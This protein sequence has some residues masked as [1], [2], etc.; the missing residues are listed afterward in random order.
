M[1]DLP[2]NI[3]DMVVIGVLLLSALLALA[4]GF[5]REVL[6]IAGWVAA[7]FITYFALPHVQKPA[8]QWVAKKFDIKEAMVADVGAGAAIFIA[9]LVVFTIITI[10]ISKRIQE[11]EIGP[12]DRSLGF[13]F[14]LVRGAFVLS[15]AYLVLIQFIPPK[16]HPKWI[17]D[18][19]SL[20]ALQSGALFLTKIS[21]E[22]V[23][24]NLKTTESWSDKLIKKLDDTGS[25][26]NDTTKKLKENY[27]DEQRKQLD[28]LFPDSKDKETKK[29]E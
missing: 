10:I 17:K 24:E 8:E 4:R 29:S 7:G 19:R 23:R 22:K 1:D 18:A 20:D 28:R 15:L 26:I 16:D 3:T 9:A 5:V 11:S 14:G 27:S 12:L 21:P 13:L 6:S 25:M 2:V